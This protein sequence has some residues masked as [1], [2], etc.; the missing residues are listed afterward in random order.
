MIQY[1][2]IEDT[3]EIEKDKLPNIVTDRLEQVLKGFGLSTFSS[4]MAIEYLKVINS[5]YFIIIIL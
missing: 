1:N 3:I 4:K 2:N 5:Y